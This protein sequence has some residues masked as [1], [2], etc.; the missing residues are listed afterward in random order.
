[1]RK[2]H[3]RHCGRGGVKLQGK[4]DPLPQCRSWFFTTTTQPTPVPP[5]WFNMNGGN[6]PFACSCYCQPISTTMI[7][8]PRGRRVFLFLQPFSCCC[9]CKPRGRRVVFLFYLTLDYTKA[10][11][12]SAANW[13]ATLMVRSRWV[14]FTGTPSALACTR[15]KWMVVL[16]CRLWTSHHHRPQPAAQQ[17]L[18]KVIAND[19]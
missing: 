1:M 6:S 7:K 11:L 19:R 17:E 15:A 16:I 2:N 13:R 4:H 8:Q 5:T 10:F 3:D 12:R 9:Y 18:E 14:W